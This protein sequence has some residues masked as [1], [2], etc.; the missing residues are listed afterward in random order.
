MSN[1]DR[2]LE[3]RSVAVVGASERAG[4]V[5]DQLMKQL[6]KGGFAGAVYPVN[7]NHQ[8]LHGLPCVPSLSELG[9]VD[10]VVLAVANARLEAEMEKAVMARAASAT[11]FASCHGTAS[12][13]TPLRERLAAIAGEM[14]ICGGNGMGFVNLAHRL[15][16]CGFYQPY[17]LEPGGVT[18]LSHSGSL[19]S[20]MLHNRRG[21]RF[22]VV[23]STGLELNT[24]MDKYMRWALGLDS[25]SVVALFLETIRDPA[26]F[27]LA[28][29]TAEERDVPVV[30][31][32]VGSSERGRDAVTTHS[33][34]VAGDDAA[35]E[36]L[37]AAHGVHRVRS[38]DEMLDTIELFAAGRRAT[39]AGL[40]AVHDSGGERALLIDVADR[41]G[42]PLPAVGTEATERIAA[43]LD[44]GLE[45]ANPIDAWGTG[46]RAVDVFTDCLLA[47]A[48]DD[49]IGA[50]TFCVDL[51]TEERSDD[52]YARAVIHVAA[53]TTKPVMVLAN[54]SSS[55][56][57]AQAKRL[58]E[59]GVPVLEGTETGLAAV[60]H[61]FADREHRSLPAPGARLTSPRPARTVPDERSALELLASYGITIPAMERADDVSAAVAAAEHLGF[62]VVL[63]AAAPGI[64]HKS[65]IGGVV[66]GLRSADEVRQQ[67]LAMAARLG[68]EVLVAAM[69]PAGVEVAF[70]MVGDP[71]FGPIVIVSAGGVLMEAMPGRIAAVPPFDAVRARRLIDRLPMRALLDGWRGSGPSDIAAIADALMRFSELALDAGPWAR[72][73]D[74]NPLIANGD[75]C[76]AVDAVVVG[77]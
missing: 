28:L 56:D 69:A 60:G 47:L 20:A 50:I 26:G 18:F 16:V 52:A 2:M 19:F 58:R 1:L 71:Q 54:L 39:A 32:R 11:I 65:D 21:V 61:L 46:H 8:R 10:N 49:A 35:Y 68:P 30:A 41:L 7:P 74:V 14:P 6:V 51:T 38:M 33:E 40:G 13:G 34:A 29:R 48:G 62:P 67:Y 12:D 5:G 76:V 25:T 73:I 59:S 45:P 63:K 44:P 4:S 77:A 43:A 24:T 9:P 53:A 70:G 55:V 31:L 42:V 27:R 72:S 37:F 66:V 17:D 22:N 75:G 36:A 15:R 57:P 23:V 64:L 3:A